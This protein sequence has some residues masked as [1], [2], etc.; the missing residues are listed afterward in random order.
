MLSTDQ[1]IGGMKTFTHNYGI[2]TKGI[3]YTD[4]DGFSINYK[5][6]AG[7]VI[8]IMIFSGK[9]VKFNE[10]VITA[11]NPVQGI[12]SSALYS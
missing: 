6:S 1:N 4:D 8:P 9:T 3:T 5:D 2:G 7:N 11:S 12:F 10:T